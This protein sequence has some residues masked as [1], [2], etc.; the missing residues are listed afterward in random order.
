MKVGFLFGAG[1]ELG[2]G[3]PSGGRFALDIF[4]ENL[5]KPK[6]ELKNMRDKIDKGTTYASKWLPE[7]F[8]SKKIHA[9]GDRVFD[10]II[11]DTV[12]NNRKKII[13]KINAF[14]TVA[15]AAVDVINNKL[16][17]DL[18]QK[19]NEDL[20]KSVS[21]IHVNQKLKYSSFFESGNSLFDNNYFAVLLEYYKNY[22][23]FSDLAKS[24]FGE[25][26]KAIFQ[27]QLG[28]M[29]EELSRNIED[30]IFARDELE[31]DIFDDLGGSLHV[32]YET[33]GV[34]G[35][36]L[37]SKDL[38]S[39]TEHPIISF[40]Y[41]IVERIYADVLDYKSLI[42]SNWHYL[43]NPYTEWAKFCRISV[44]LFTVQTY[45]VNQ[46]K[47]INED[48]K[49]YYDD[50]K[51]SDIET[52]IVGTTN[53]NSFIQKK[54]NKKIIYLNGGV[55]EYYDP[56]L[57]AIGTKENLLK[58]EE[59]F[60]VPLLFTQSGTKPMTSIDMAK[61]YVDFYEKM[62]SGD[63]ICSVGFGFNY[64]DEHINGII[65]KLVDQDDKHLFIIDIEVEKTSDE[66]RNYYGE[67][68]KISNIRNIK[69]I[70]VNKATRLI[71][72][73]KWTDVLKSEIEKLTLT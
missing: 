33:A 13:S 66:K 1:A 5:E 22:T 72:D 53:Y 18:N 64:D 56:Y 35:L 67:K 70:T 65:R 55:N 50:L 41:E 32:N 12:G 73:R 23:D 57:N 54:L 16:D 40:A 27:L 63:A 62:K 45:I 10:A 68:L 52:T 47:S 60:I 71:D 69:F 34:K 19:I 9:F 20:G 36:E 2:Y 21:N 28:A 7:D 4:R 59:H 14:D 49:G 26:I 48:N 29:S 44:F 11:R 25:V 38:V 37:L 31:L 6:L 51:E 42:D 8:Y 30:N 3:M 61:K 39:S 17:I 58:E 46:A 15:S 24:E 43:Y